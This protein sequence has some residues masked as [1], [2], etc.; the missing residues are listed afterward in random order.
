LGLITST[1]ISLHG[2]SSN[3]DLSSSFTSLDKITHVKA[4]SLQST[5]TQFSIFFI[6]I[7]LNFDHSFMNGIFIS[8]DLI[9]KVKGVSFAIII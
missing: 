4:Q 3:F 7:P 2:F 1:S 9:C 5:N 6:I 8:P